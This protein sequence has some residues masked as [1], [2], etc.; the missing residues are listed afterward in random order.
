MDAT[1]RSRG[2]TLL[3]WYDNTIFSLIDARSFSRL[4]FWIAL[5]TVWLV[6][7][8][9]VLG[10]PFGIVRRATRN[11]EQAQRDMEDLVRIHVRRLYGI[12]R[13][14]G[15]WIVGTACAVLTGLGLVGFLYRVELA[16]AL[17]LMFIPLALSGALNLLAAFR[18]H[19]QEPTGGALLRQMWWLRNR[20]QLIG[21]A[22]ILAS[23]MWGMSSISPTAGIGG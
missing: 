6:A 3:S 19:H 11:S 5:V 12:G 4:W 16:Q 15:I 13:A 17:F 14:F 2:R 23:V 9:W 7:G 1:I 22:T 20:I 10:V 8:N 18:I 21:V